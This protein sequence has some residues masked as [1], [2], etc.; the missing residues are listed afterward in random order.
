MMKY[1]Y[2]EFRR[3]LTFH[4]KKLSGVYVFMNDTV[5][6]CV[7]SV[8]TRMYVDIQI[9]SDNF[10]I[11]RTCINENLIQAPKH[12]YAHLREVSRTTTI[13]HDISIVYVS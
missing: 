10:F 2:I 13:T 5:N 4:F 3:K 12:F 6:K 11:K 8:H 7:F 9:Q 1:W